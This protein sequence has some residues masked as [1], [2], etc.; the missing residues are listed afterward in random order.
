MITVREGAHHIPGFLSREE[1]DRLAAR[2]R[3]LGD[4]EAG[5]YQPVARGLGKMRLR[6]LCLG[7]HWNARTYRY[8]PLRTDAD[9]LPAPPLPA[10]LAD[11][12][13]RAANAAGM[14][15]DPDVAIVNAYGEDGRLGTH[16]DKD[17]R[18]ETLAAGVP[19]VSI[20]LGDTG[21]FLFGGTRRRDP[22]EKILLQSGDAFV[23]G[24]PSRL[25]YHG[26][27][28]ILPGTAPP[29]FPFPGR[30][31]ITFRQY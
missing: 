14:S 27:G 3:E 23:F 28:R 18:P 31:N 26:V 4:A 11:V 8:E 20:S 30:I 21:A 22:V 24:G 9:G 10:D 19:V 5:F 15:I 2:V 17:E 12:A 16:Q 25:C 7:L 29:G 13:R 1:Q 6:M